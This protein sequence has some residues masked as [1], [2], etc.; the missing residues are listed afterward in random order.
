MSFSKSVILEECHVFNSGQRKPFEIELEEA[1]IS[2]RQMVPCSLLDWFSRKTWTWSYKEH[3]HP[4]PQNHLDTSCRKWAHAF[5]NRPRVY[6]ETT[7]E[8][9]L[10]CQS[11]IMSSDSKR[12]KLKKPSSYRRLSA[13][14]SASV[15]AP[16][17]LSAVPRAPVPKRLRAE[18]T[19]RLQEVC[20]GNST[21][22]Y[23]TLIKEFENSKAFNRLMQ[24]W[25]NEELARHWCNVWIKASPTNRYT[26]YH[27]HLE[28]GIQLSAVSKV[29]RLVMKE[30]FNR[31]EFENHLRAYD[32][33]RCK[34]D[35]DT[36]EKRRLT[37]E[38]SLE[39]FSAAKRRRQL[40]RYQAVV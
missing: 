31:S 1:A 16:I 24:G 20:H 38:A 34:Q 40:V 2:C 4:I 22:S 9:Y 25:R 6:F 33:L 15:V 39:R 17:R 14:A 13:S 29:T 23:D 21:E 5:W 30:F 10:H 35:Q 36:A 7:E 27:Y 37:R 12:A 28:Q 32:N 3:D 18:R 8:S 19:T 11:R 26:A